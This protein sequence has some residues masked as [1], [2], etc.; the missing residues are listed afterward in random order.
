MKISDYFK[1]KVELVTFPYYI[2]SSA[3]LPLSVIK[4][5]GGSYF[6]R[7]RVVVHNCEKRADTPDS[8]NTP[9]DGSA[10]GSRKISSV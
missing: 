4:E 5:T 6:G 10:K 9:R 7:L 3:L 1:Q 2:A 8:E